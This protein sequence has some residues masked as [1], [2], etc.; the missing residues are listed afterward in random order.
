[1]AWHCSHSCRHA[2]PCMRSELKQ[3]G[4][5]F[6]PR[7]SAA[8]YSIHLRSNNLLS[9]PKAPHKISCRRIRLH[10]T[11]QSAM[12]TT[13]RVLAIYTYNWAF[14]ATPE[15]RL[16][17]QRHAGVLVYVIRNACCSHL[18]APTDSCRWWQQAVR[19]EQQVQDGCR[20][21]ASFGPAGGF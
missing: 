14:W 1:M 20:R 11:L 3:L 13:V 21:L 6:W 19:G 7:S 12:N 2:D 18:L 4:A 17:D 16:S 8:A 15:T 5:T 9:L 10:K